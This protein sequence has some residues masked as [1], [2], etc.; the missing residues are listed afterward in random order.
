[1]PQATPSCRIVGFL[2]DERI[3]WGA[4]DVISESLADTGHVVAELGVHGT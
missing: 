1:M 4:V 2:V 3:P